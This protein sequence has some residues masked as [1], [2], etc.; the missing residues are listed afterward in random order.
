[1]QKVKG[2]VLKNKI[3]LK[4]I[5]ISA[6]IMIVLLLG[7]F[8]TLLFFSLPAI[9][10]NGFS[11][12]WGK[13][14]DPVNEHYGMLPFLIGT[15][16]T[17]FL[18]LLIS[19]PFSISAALFLGEYFPKGMIPNIFRNIIELLAAIP[20]VVYGF[21]GLFTIVPLVRAL[22]LKLH[23]PA[24]GLGIFSA[25]LVLS[26]MLIPYSVSLIRQVIS[27]TPIQLKEAAYALGCTRS[28]VIM[29]V[30]LPTN[31]S[32]ISAGFLLSLGRAL[33][34]TMAVTV[35]IGNATQL[36]KSIFS[37]SN[38]MAS[39]IANEFTEAVS[40]VYS[41]SLVEIGL[42]LFVVTTII[43]LIGRNIIKRFAVKL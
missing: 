24:M 42:L 11:F 43:N 21:W 2:K 15:L 22:E 37:P 17:S 16:V 36:P 41:S 5:K 26:I 23:M 6:V 7:F 39:L 12:L 3:F 4:W 29:K 31:L 40:T 10:A 34:E 19:A 33:G 32:G 1:M 9:K 28:E 27:M 30:I 14:W 13:T 38:T 25:S 35:L 20:S 18:A 8:L